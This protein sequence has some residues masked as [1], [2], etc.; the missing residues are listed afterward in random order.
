MPRIHVIL[1]VLALSTLSDYAN[2]QYGAYQ[3]LHHWSFRP[4]DSDQSWGFSEAPSNLHIDLLR[5]DSI[6]EP[7][8]SDHEEQLQWISD[9][10]WIYEHRLPIPDAVLLQEHA[11][12]VFE[13][14]DGY[15]EVYIN[16]QLV[17]EANNQF[18]SWRIPIN[19]F[20]VDMRQDLADN[21][22]TPPAP[23]SHGGHDHSMHM[24]PPNPPN[25]DSKQH[26]HTEGQ[27]HDH[28][29]SG[30][31]QQ[32]HDQHDHSNRSGHDN[33]DAHA[34]HT[35]HGGHGMAAGKNSLAVQVIFR[36]VGPKE[37]KA[38]KDWGMEMPG[39][40]RV[41]TRKA[42]YQYGWD[43][44]PSF[45]TAGISK[46][47]YVKSWDDVRL[48]NVWYETLEIAE[49]SAAVRAHIRL[50][51]DGEHE[52]ELDFGDELP[53][54][55][56]QVKTSV[57]IQELT[58]DMEISNPRL[59][60]AAGMGAP[61]LYRARLRIFKDLSPVDQDYTQIGIRTIKLVTEADEF[62]ESFY[63]E[64][65]G[66][67][68]FA[69]G[70]NWIPTSSFVIGYVPDYLRLFEDVK[71]SNFNMLRVWG[72]GIYEYDVFYDLCNRN[73]ILVWQDFMFACA[74]YPGDKDFLENVK[75]EAEEQV[76]RLRNH[77]SL[78]L[79]CGNN[80]VA[81]AW[82][83]WGWQDQY[84]KKKRKKI[85]RAYEDLF[86]DLLPSVLSEKHPQLDYVHSSPRFG[87][88]DVRY[89]SEGDAHDWWVW[90]DAFPFEH[91]QQSIPRFMS[92]FGMQAYPDIR[93]VSWYADELP[94]KFEIGHPQLALHQ[95]H[96]RGDS[97]VKVYIERNYRVNDEL[98]AYVYLSQIMQAHGMRKAIEAQRRS[99]RCSGSLY[100]QLNDV[101]PVT[102]WSGIDYFGRWK[103]M[104]HHVKRAFQSIS[105][106][107][108]VDSTGKINV[109][110]VYDV[111]S[112]QE[113]LLR[114]Q[115]MDVNGQV[116][117]EEQVAL[118]MEAWSSGILWQG[119]AGALLGSQNPAKVFLYASLH[120]PEVA[121][122]DGVFSEAGTNTFYSLPLSDCK[123]YF[124]RPK[125]MELPKGK[126]QFRVLEIDRD[127]PV[128]EIQSDVLLRDVQIVT[129]QEGWF[130]DNFF[131]I[132]PGETKYVRFYPKSEH[133][134]PGADLFSFSDFS[135][136]LRLV[137][138]AEIQP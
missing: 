1:L 10:D 91:F 34:G 123:L 138:L 127:N 72:G 20:L 38:Q 114:I 51:S 111:A 33:H 100:W 46:N 21:P 64:L 67:K 76:E 116:I 121:M 55:I 37:A 106:S 120:E 48:L 129:D 90:H 42:A 54:N 14:L 6:P 23:P 52:I 70:A 109:W 4:A 94:E 84:S 40:S 69:K 93:T 135:R 122:T 101:W 80:E 65:N 18:R 28:D 74:M 105:L 130:E 86:Q 96:P 124:A 57:G 88:G 60:W 83:R 117:H 35:G 125:E 5:L 132:V 98:E 22:P 13:G 59:W 77:P 119:S 92:E 25:P 41:F 75:L 95:K 99:P 62:G 85:E 31:N 47:V 118:N 19:D 128:V 56:H 27:D 61:N 24:D 89:L 102:S 82:A 17:L 131:D 9:K 136:H 15:A 50:E 49:E 3:M 71:R 110:G 7:F 66:Q 30:H 2:A 26:E 107:A 81:E 73:G 104:Q 8:F 78:A 108:E 97:L 113:Y 29:H 39:G 133:I 58:F 11:E 45:I 36:A 134:N 137:H 103:A 53:S 16:G 87:R 12:L 79:W 32:N 63:F 126:P 43:W 44:G 115:I 68:L 112:T